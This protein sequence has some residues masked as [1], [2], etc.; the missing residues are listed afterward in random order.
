MDKIKALLEKAG[1]KIEVIDSICEALDTYKVSIRESYDAEYKARVEDAKKVCVEEVESHKR[2]LARRLQIFCET[3]SAAIEAQLAKQSALSESE[4]TTKLKNIMSLLEGVEPNSV[5]NG[6]TTA[7]L[8]KARHQLQ[9]VN[10]EKQKA[11]TVANRQSAI[12][13]KALKQNRR[14]AS[15]IASLKGK[16]TEVVSE[17]RAPKLGKRIDTRRSTGT[18]VT[19]RQT[20]LE[21]QDRRPISKNESMIRSEP[22]KNGFGIADIAED[23][24]T[25][26]I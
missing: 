22:N 21:N 23:M 6:A 16:L 20:L 2:E 26:L 15:E 25:D 5:A 1:C 9:Q 8:K 3:K 18:P 7:A 17:S 11:V 4:A 10:E 24:D 13:E 19:T 14:M 12:A